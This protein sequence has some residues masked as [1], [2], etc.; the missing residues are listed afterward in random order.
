M[1]AMMELKAI[2]L[3]CSLQ[4]CEAAD[5]AV[6]L[7]GSPARQRKRT[8]QIQKVQYGRGKEEMAQ[9]RRADAKS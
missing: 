5:H 9:M 4:P 6:L 2:G 1:C 3:A 7:P 8:R